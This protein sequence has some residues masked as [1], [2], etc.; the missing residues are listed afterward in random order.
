MLF[1]ICRRFLCIQRDA[2]ASQSADISSSNFDF[3]DSENQ[4]TS[5]D[6]NSTNMRELAY[7]AARRRMLRERQEQQETWN[8]SFYYY[9]YYYFVRSCLPNSFPL[10][11]LLSFFIVFLY[12]FLSFLL[13]AV[14]TYILMPVGWEKNVLPVNG[15]RGWLQHQWWPLQ[16][17]DFVIACVCTLWEFLIYKK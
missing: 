14:S 5:S 10:V 17:F 8:K 16:K 11:F 1:C 13:K 12:L 4:Q 2:N 7:Q 15:R 9:Y 3:M 6:R